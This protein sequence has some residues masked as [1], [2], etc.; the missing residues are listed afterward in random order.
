MFGSSQSAI[1]GSVREPVGMREIG[2]TA[3]RDVR[4]RTRVPGCNLVP[5][6]LKIH[7]P[8]SQPAAE[9]VERLDEIV[10]P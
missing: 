5:P 3:T 7:G 9:V 10:H 1:C 4:P 8:D 2:R 6:F